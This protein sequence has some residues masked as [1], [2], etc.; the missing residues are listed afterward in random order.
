MAT[1]EDEW[2]YFLK[3]AAALLA[4]ASL[5]GHAVALGLGWLAGAGCLPNTADCEWP[6]L[7]PLRVARTAT[8]Y[9]AVLSLLVF[10]FSL[11]QD[12]RGVALEL[13]I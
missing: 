9:G 1:T 13:N 2:D 6:D 5:L 4:A 7:C 11:R 12:L 8:A 3:K 10:V